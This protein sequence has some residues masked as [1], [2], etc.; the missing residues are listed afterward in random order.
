ML[1][2]QRTAD[3]RMEENGKITARDPLAAVFTPNMFGDLVMLCDAILIVASGVIT[4]YVYHQL[5]YSYSGDVEVMAAISVLAAILFAGLGRRAQLYRAAVL[6][7]WELQSGSLLLNWSLMFLMVATLAFATKS[8]EH[9]S[10]GWLVAW[11]LDGALILLMFHAG[12]RFAV[13]RLIDSGWI[14]RRRVAIVGAT[15]L[16]RRFIKFQETQ[17]GVGIEFVGVFDDGMRMRDPDGPDV[18]GTVDD[19]IRFAQTSAVDDVVI[20]LPWSNEAAVYETV[21][22]LSILPCGAYLCPELLGSRFDKRNVKLIGNAYVVEANTRALAGWRAVWKIT[23]DRV[24]AAVAL[25]VLLP[26]FLAIGLAIKLGSRGPV[27]FRQRRHGFN[28]QVFFIYKFRT[29]T[30]CED[31]DVIAQATKNDQRITR[32]GAFLRRTSLDELPQIINVIWGEMSLVGPRPHAVAHN[33]EYTGLI[34]DY[35]V[36]HRVLPGMTGWAQVNGFR[37]ETPNV[38]AMRKRIQCDLYYVENWSPLLDLKIIA[39]TVR[40][41]VAAKGAY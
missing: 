33:T 36:R 28:H 24:L 14:Q 35:A 41:I 4:G 25:L 39:M 19:L 17:S 13:R 2:S 7:K 21:R 6:R 3:V 20:A 16:A 22:R 38:E 8:T 27:F 32:V 26:A 30:V 23:Q 9:F 1:A 37:G 31:G 12:V 15:A 34:E 29:M 5:K 10:R 11:F 18:T 40:A